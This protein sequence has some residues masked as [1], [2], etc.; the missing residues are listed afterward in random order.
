MPASFR[1]GL[2]LKFHKQNADRIP[3][4]EWNRHKE[5]LVYLFKEKDRPLKEIVQYMKDERQFNASERQYRS[6]FK[7]WKVRK[8]AAGRAASTAASNPEA[9]HG[10][11]AGSL[12][13]TP[14]YEIE[15]QVPMMQRISPFKHP[16]SEHSRSFSDSGYASSAPSAPARKRFKQGE[17][18]S[19]E[20]VLS[21]S[22]VYGPRKLHSNTHRK[23][24]SE[25]ISP[26]YA[27][28]V[29]L[30][31]W[32]GKQQLLSAISPLEYCSK[33][34]SLDFSRTVDTYDMYELRDMERAADF[35]SSMGLAEKAFGIYVLLL[36]HVLACFPWATRGRVTRLKIACARTA[37]N[38]TDWEIVD[39]LLQQNHSASEDLSLIIE[40]FKYGKLVLTDPMYSSESHKIDALLNELPP[41]DRSLDLLLFHLI[42]IQATSYGSIEQA[43]DILIQLRPGPFELE[44][45]HMRNPCLR[46]CLNWCVIEFSRHWG[47]ADICDTIPERAQ[48]LKFAV[49]CLFCFFWKRWQSGQ[50]KAQPDL[51]RWTYDSEIRAG[52]SACEF[53]FT[54]TLLIVWTYFD[55][56]SLNAHWLSWDYDKDHVSV[57]LQSAIQLAQS[58][59]EELAR[60]FLDV[61]FK[62]PKDSSDPIAHV[63]TIESSE[64]SLGQ[65][66]DEAAGPF[67]LAPITCCAESYRTSASSLKNSGISSFQ[68]LTQSVRSLRIDS[69]EQPSSA[70]KEASRYGLE[71]PS[72]SEHS[73]G[74]PRSLILPSL[75]E[76]D[77]AS[78]FDR[79]SVAD[80]YVDATV[81]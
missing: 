45:M 41:E 25:E 26:D 76:S 1:E 18:A 68:R 50:N 33:I 24:S 23:S 73:Y 11:E 37:R 39:S 70:F 17:L 54:V 67:C 64:T 14:E 74:M 57:I 43:K 78:G 48:P 9:P 5:E 7:D 79:S 55:L 51:L 63:V 62:K 52:I 27:A 16:R 38:E 6:R 30:N 65:E 71:V 80:S 75:S 77:E 35:L 31:N 58:S 34:S 56:R 12:L 47:A 40:G 15:D 2:R 44:G 61:V 21:D 29:N 28:D 22:S 3:E 81:T 53:L 59:D 66:H 8:Y 46:S 36:K 69:A 32:T 49:E 42:K 20:E 72:I 10:G 13:T 19:F 4:S 60:Q